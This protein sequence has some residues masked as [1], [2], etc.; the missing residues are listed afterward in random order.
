MRRLQLDPKKIFYERQAQTII[1]ALER[2]QITGHY[3]S[4]RNEA[5]EYIVNS[6]ETGMTLSWGGSVTLDELGLLPRLREMDLTLYDREL[7]VTAEE[8]D[9]VNSRAL[10]ADYYLMSTNAITLDGKLINI[11]GRGNRLAALMFGPKKV[12]VV[13]GMN[14]VVT[15]EEDGINRVRNIASPANSIRLSR[16]TPCAVNGSCADCLSD[17]CICSHT[18]ITRRS[19][20]PGRLTV[21]LVGEELGF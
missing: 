10:L 11:D 14:K 19:I 4:D 18:V 12:F 15:N 5:R 2:R 9:E 8:K 7:A 16:N 13:A 20:E 21:I 17:D 6:I 3:A 1:K